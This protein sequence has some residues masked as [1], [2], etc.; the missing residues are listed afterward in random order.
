MLAAVMLSVVLLSFTAYFV[1]GQDKGERESLSGLNSPNAILV[2]L[3]TGKVLGEKKADEKIYPASLTKIMTAVL[4]V[5][6]IGDLQERITVP[7][8]IFPKLYEEGASMAGF[9]PGEEA[10]GLDLLY[11]VLLPSG[12]ECCL[13]FADRIAGSEEDFVDMMNEKAKEL[14][15]E[16]THFT[17]ST[18]LQDEDH[19]STVRDISV[20][21]RYALAGDTF[22]Q[23][24]TSSSY[25]TN[26][27][28][29]HPEGFT[30]YSTMFQEM[31]SAAVTDGEIL[32]GKTGYTKEAG[33]CL[34]SLAVIGQKEYILITAHARGD[35]E[36]RQYHVE[37]AVKV[38]TQLGKQ[39]PG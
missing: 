20:L 30:F 9:C 23:V 36:T 35:H 2:E 13:T 37:D 1:L 24:F 19:Y 10:V 39:L 17:N 4:A 6:N 26:P 5:E 3:E 22:R 27:S 38:Y 28:A 21:L 33:L 12:A 29:C 14:G 15:M 18:G 8:E 32:G 34:A 31:N 11:G 16:H 7:E 25:S